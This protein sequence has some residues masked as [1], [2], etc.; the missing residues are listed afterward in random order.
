[1]HD[2]R[3]FAEDHVARIEPLSREVNLQKVYADRGDFARL[4]A[5]RK[6]KS[7]RDQVE[8]R[9]LE[10]LYR[11][12]LRNQVDPDLIE[13]T[14]RL[15]SQI[16]RAFGTYRVS[17]EGKELTGNDVRTVLKTSTDSSHRR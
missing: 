3:S 5:W 13:A 6:D 12:Y 14:T 10:L 17:V 1:M 11:A 9:Q 15:S 4:D 8:A 7:A 2:F 16:V